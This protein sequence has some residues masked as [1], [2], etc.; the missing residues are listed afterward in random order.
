MIAISRGNCWTYAHPRRVGRAAFS[1]IEVLV[2]LSIILIGSTIALSAYAAQAR[3]ASV[4]TTAQRLQRAMVFA[5]QYA[6]SKNAEAT[7]WIDLDRQVFWIDET[8]PAADL[9]LPV[10]PAALVPKVLEPEEV[11]IGATI[12]EVRVGSLVY[13]TGRA[14]VRFSATGSNPYAGAAM[15]R[16]IDDP[17]DPTKFTTVLLYPNSG[18]PRLLPRRRF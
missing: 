9:S 4:K 16:K 11:P 15:I 12:T 8:D 2:V 17:G 5:K 13:N 6:V 18:D 14:F 10:T 3:D 1:F 7:L